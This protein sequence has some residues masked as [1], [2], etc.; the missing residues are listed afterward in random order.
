MHLAIVTPY[1]PD[2]TGIGQYG[3]HISRALAQSE[4]FTQITVLAGA[5]S[6]APRVETTSPVNVIYTWQPGHP[7][8]APAIMSVLRQRQP[9][10][11]WFNL[12]VSVFGRAP[13]DNLLGL[14]S[15]QRV[16]LAGLPTVVTLHEVVELADLKTLRAPYGWLA[17]LGARVFTQIASR[18]DVV[19]LTTS[20]YV[21]W[22]SRRR[23]RLACVHIPIG[24]YQTPEQLAETDLPELLFFSSLAP[25]KG[26]ELLLAAFQLLQ[27]RYPALRL[28]VA[29]AAHP[30][31]PGYAATLRREYGGLPG[32]RWLGQVPE[33][34]LRELYAQ[35]QIVILPYLASTGSSSVLFQAAMWNRPLVASNLVETQAVAAESGLAV[36]FFKSRDPK[37]LAGAIQLL[38]DSP[39]RRQAQAEQNFVAIQRRRPEVTCQAYLQAF[40]L[41]LSTHRN[42]KR[43][44]VPA[45]LPPQ[46][47]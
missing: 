47:A 31:F 30:R 46:L 39:V 5:R 21:S 19:C 24:A 18:A 13:L 41:A 11:V 16:R 1:P 2:I 8:A 14:L 33:S 35:A 45:G 22:F 20:R 36:E 4:Q 37:S 15:L 34:R 10:V 32:V 6:A 23:P 29:G 44:D 25:Y 17:P 9:D 27:S 7:G 42:P 3:Y 43:I 28:T 26:L 12:G 38:L 40:N